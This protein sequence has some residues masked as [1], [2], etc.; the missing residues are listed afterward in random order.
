[1]DFDLWPQNVRD[2]LV[3]RQQAEAW[4]DAENRYMQETIFRE[5]GVRWSE[6]WRLPY[7]DPTHQLVVDAMH[8]LLEGLA[9]QH[10]HHTLKLTFD[11]AN[12]KAPLQRPSVM[13]LLSL[14][15]TNS[16]KRCPFY[17]FSAHIFLFG[18]P[19]TLA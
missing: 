2:V 12:A 15:V 4:R 16:P 10:F 17:H 8:C 1:M 19:P 11:D 9:Q 13:C 7:W 18:T 6:M 5:H 14:P 3:L